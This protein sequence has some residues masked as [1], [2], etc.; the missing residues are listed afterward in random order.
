MRAKRTS[1]ANR[2]REAFRLEPLE[3]RVLLSADPVLG[4]ARTVMLPDRDED[5]LSI[6]AYDSAHRVVAQQATQSST[7]VVAQI[8][9]QAS[10]SRGMLEFS[11]D[12]AAFDLATVDQSLGFL[13]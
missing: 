9:R 10:H 12:Q 3:P 4:A 1:I 2:L 13:D 11:V 8:L 5:Q 6:E 7:Q